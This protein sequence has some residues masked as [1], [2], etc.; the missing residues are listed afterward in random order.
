[1]FKRASIINCPIFRDFENPK[2]GVFMHKYFFH[3]LKLICVGE[4]HMR[5][6]K[7]QCLINDVCY[8]DVSSIIKDSNH[9]VIRDKIIILR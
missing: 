1:M 2:F 4:H 6:H 7:G 8:T 9:I 5:K 3:Y